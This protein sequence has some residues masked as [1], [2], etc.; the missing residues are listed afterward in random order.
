[1]PAC[2]ACPAC[3]A[4]PVSPTF[5]VHF[6]A[7]PDP[8]VERTRRHQLLD[9]LVI[10]LCATLCGADD[11]VAM[12]AWGRAKKDW[13]KERLGLE[14]ENGIASHDTF[15]RVF[16]RLDPQAF[17]NCF[18]AWTKALHTHTKGQ[19]IALDGKQLRRSFDA[20]SGKAA[21]H[22]VSAWATKSRLVLAQT[23]VEENS[24]EI[25]AVP[26][27][28]A[29]LD[30]EGCIVTLDAMGCQKTIAKQVV[31]QGGDYVLALKR[32]HGNLYESVVQFFERSRQSG[33]RTGLGNIAHRYCCTTEKG[34]GRIETRRCFVVDADIAWLDPDQEWSNLRS[35]ALVERERRVGHKVSVE[36]RYFLC[37][38]AGIGSARQLQRAVRRHWHTEN[39]QHWVLDV[40]FREDDC[41]IR[42][43]NAAQ[44]MAA[45]R[46]L[47]LN[48]LGQEKSAGVGVKNKRCRAGWD[49]DYLERVLLTGDS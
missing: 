2:P 14:L 22:L 35:V 15:G 32:N 19:V 34:H 30:I 11:F 23:K 28:L 48:L 36:V 31:E 12:A 29:L 44:N 49:S 18:V 41:R 42:K 7:L 13:L 4:S 1:M 3:P 27:L 5:T 37:S 20:A 6:A 24:N 26:K 39:R 40:S 10:A 17:A 38:L 25:T 21:L 46:R 33:W 45:L 47:A 8:R 9:I 43:D 16:A